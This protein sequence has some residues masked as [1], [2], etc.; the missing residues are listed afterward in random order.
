MG[1]KRGRRDEVDITCVKQSHLLLVE[2][3]PRLSGAFQINRYYESDLD[4][5]RRI[6][7]TYGYAGLRELF[8]KVHQLTLPEEGTLHLCLAANG[9]GIPIPSDFVVLMTRD[10]TVTQLQAGQPPLTL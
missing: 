10:T 9:P 5:L 4:K 7:D 1:V 3:K 6:R 2:C 8:L